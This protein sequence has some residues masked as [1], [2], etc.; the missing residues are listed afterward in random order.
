MTHIPFL[1][2]IAAL[3]TA[4]CWSV[5]SL[6]FAAAT[7]RVGSVMVNVTRLIL[8]LIL[9]FLII[10]LSGLPLGFS[11]EQY[12][13]LAA[14]GLIGLVFGDS[15]LFRAYQEI[16]PRISML[17]M[18]LAPAFSALLAYFILREGLSAWGIGGIGVTMGG[19]GVVVAGGR[20]DPVKSRPNLRGIVY[21]V[22]ASAGQG[23]GLI[24]ARM[25]FD[26]GPVPGFSAA[27]LRIAAAV[28]V[29]TPAAALS[30]RYG[31]P[32]PIFSRDRRALFLVLTGAVF[33]PV[34]GIT[35]SMVSITY[36]HVGVAATLMATVPV[37]MLPLI[38][39]VY[40][41]RISWRAILGA[42]VAVGGV[43]MLFLAPG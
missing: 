26:R 28:L 41:E 39:F 1:G 34:L 3:V 20:N 5:T 19:I 36:A 14:S 42:V 27:F 15:F 23:I 38:R 35:L 6:S 2:E 12:L 30:G 37:L 40:R 9:L 21:A 16:G 22:F 13:L 10:A 32:I 29:L 7:R 25:A 11:T 8:A 24:V 18:S 17:I 4:A 33:G 31:N 43:A